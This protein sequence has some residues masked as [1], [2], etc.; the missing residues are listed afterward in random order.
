MT[1]HAGFSWHYTGHRRSDFEAA[2]G[3]F[4]L[5]A[6]SQVDAHI[7]VD[8]DRFS[9]DAFVHN[10]TDSRGIVNLGTFGAAPS[11]DFAASIIRPRTIGASL[12]VRY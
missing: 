8:I 1:G 7:G 9:I 2:V 11:G 3:Q 10:L 5:K 4:D 12:R 6:F